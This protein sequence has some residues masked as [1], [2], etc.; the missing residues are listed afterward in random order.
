MK[1]IE[2]SCV[3]LFFMG[4]LVAG[5]EADAIW[6]WNVAAGAVMMVAAGL[7]ANIFADKNTGN[8]RHPGD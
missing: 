8:N 1:A 5:S 7:G 6:P 3:L 2:G 4:V